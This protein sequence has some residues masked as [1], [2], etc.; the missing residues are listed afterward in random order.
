LNPLV[1]EAIDAF[2]PVQ[3]QFNSAS[4]PLRREANINAE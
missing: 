4:V 3:F 2:G 1:R